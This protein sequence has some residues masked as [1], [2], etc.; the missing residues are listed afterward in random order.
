MKHRIISVPVWSSVNVG[1]VRLI[2]LNPAIGTDR[3]EENWKEIHKNVVNAAYDLIKLKG[4]TSWAIGLCAASFVES[5]LLNSNIVMAA[6]TYV[7]VSKSSFV[8][9]VFC[10]YA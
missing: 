5:I 1:G 7:K 9:I 3:D 4:Y 2:E 6:S 10:E 8:D